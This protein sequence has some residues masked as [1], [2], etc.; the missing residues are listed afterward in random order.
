MKETVLSL[1]DLNMEEMDLSNVKG[2]ADADYSGT[3]IDART[4]KTVKEYCV[5]HEDGSFELAYTP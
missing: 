1:V 5:C 3:G 2:G 4:G